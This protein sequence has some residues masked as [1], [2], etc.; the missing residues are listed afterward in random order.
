VMKTYYISQGLLKTPLEVEIEEPPPCLFCGEAV[1]RPSMDGPLVCGSCD[2]GRNRDGS[3]WTDEERAR[4]W[5][6]RRTQ[7]AK[8]HE[9]SAKRLSTLREGERAEEQEGVS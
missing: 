8:Y 6:H 5:S 4:A 2:C 1:T 7:I 3:K 9:A